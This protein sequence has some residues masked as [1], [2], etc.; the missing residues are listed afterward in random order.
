MYAIE[1]SYGIVSGILPDRFEFKNDAD[2][3][4]DIENKHYNNI[5]HKV[6]ECQ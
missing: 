4:C 2:D 3:A 5:T 6:I 1:F